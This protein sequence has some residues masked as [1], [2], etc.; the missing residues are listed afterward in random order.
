MSAL[1]EA[2]SHHYREGHAK[3][4]PPMWGDPRTEGVTAFKPA[5][6]LIAITDKAESDGF[7]P[8]V[9]LIHRPDTMRAHPG[10]IALPG[11]RRDPGEDAIQ[12][13][14]REA[15][16][17]LGIDQTQVRVI[18][19]SDT[20]HSGSGYEITPV[21]A[22]V[23]GDIA[24]TPNPAEVA[25]WFEVPLAHVLDP[26]NHAVRELERNGKII[27]FVEILWQGHMIWGVTGAILS[28]LSKR[29]EWGRK[30]G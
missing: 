8:G 6:V 17:E 16:E 28:N 2:L 11:G 14:L 9:L 7:G 18:G 10:Q 29:L 27:P 23:P 3:P 1:L 25:S 21:L 4:A 22:V 13:A 15:E 30:D 5:S 26:A 24:I 20:F 12:A 19:T